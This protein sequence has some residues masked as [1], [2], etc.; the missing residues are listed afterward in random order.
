MEMKKVIYSGQDTDEVTLEM[1]KGEAKM[2]KKGWE[3]RRVDMLSS[4]TVQVTYVRGSEDDE[5]EED[6]E[7]ED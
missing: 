5:D 1:E 6:D 4:S 7:E 3:A 2:A